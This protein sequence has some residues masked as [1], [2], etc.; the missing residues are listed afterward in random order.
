MDPSSTTTWRDRAVLLAMVV[1]MTAGLVPGAIDI[2]S[3]LGPITS[4]DFCPI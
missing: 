3:A 2:A 4:A 1:M